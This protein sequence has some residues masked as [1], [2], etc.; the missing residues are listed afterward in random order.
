MLLRLGVFTTMAVLPVLWG[1]AD[2]AAPRRAAFRVTLTGTLTKDWRTART[3]EDNCNVT[4]TSTGR[5]KL[6]LATRAPS[7]VVFVRPSS[8]RR[9]LRI[10]L[11]VV[12]TIAGQASQSGVVQTVSSGVGCLRRTERR[13][14]PQQRRSFRGATARLTVPRRGIARFAPLQGASAARSFTCPEQLPGV[15]ALGTDLGLADAPL[16]AADVFDDNVARFFITANTQQDTTLE[17]DY[18]G[19]VI[20]RVRWTL[21]FTRIG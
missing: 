13:P 11:S 15:R 14:C 4:T 2:A 9:P 18:T 21:T 3:V 6:T 19:T 16:T 10:S 12:R 17:G 5:W 8:P 1:A 7:R 20:E